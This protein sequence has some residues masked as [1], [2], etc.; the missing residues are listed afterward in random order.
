M[1]RAVV[2]IAALAAAL[3]LT[4]CGESPED[5]ARDQGEQVGES[6][7]ALYDA[8][9]AEDAGEAIDDLRGAVEDI[10]EDTRERVRAQVD[11]QSGSLDVAVEALGAGDTEALQQTAQQIRSQADSFRSGNDSIANEFWHGF[12]DGYDD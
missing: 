4:G 9:S 11:T 5:E 6:V 3:A 10:S 12:E 7:R 8:K 2:T 1:S